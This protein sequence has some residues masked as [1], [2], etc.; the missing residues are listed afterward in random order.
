MPKR[1]ARV[2]DHQTQQY[3]RGGHVPIGQRV[4][5]VG[6]RVHEIWQRDDLQP[7]QVNGMS[8]GQR[9]ANQGN[10]GEGRIHHPMR[11][12]CRDTGYL[13]RTRG[14]IRQSHSEPRDES[15]EEAQEDEQPQLPVQLHEHLPGWLVLEE[16]TA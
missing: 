7:A 10:A 3:P 8:I 12:L 11:N 9:P 13:A 2:R 6:A 15:D 1:R 14:M 16:L 4:G 5:E